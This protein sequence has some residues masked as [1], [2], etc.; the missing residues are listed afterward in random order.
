MEKQSQRREDEATRTLRVLKGEVMFKAFRFDGV[1]VKE[2]DEIIDFKGEIS[3]FIMV[4]KYGNKIL[5][6]TGTAWRREFYPSV[7]NLQ[8]REEK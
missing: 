1:E 3:K 8:I 2:G 7:F 6:E 5:V 4:T